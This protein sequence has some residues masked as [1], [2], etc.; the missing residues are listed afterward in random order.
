[1]N[2]F[3]QVPT[4]QTPCGPIFAHNRV[5]HF[6]GFYLS[7]NWRDATTAICGQ[8]FYL[9]LNGDHREGMASAANNGV[10]ALAK[11]FSDNIGQVSATSEHPWACGMTKTDPLKTRE[12]ALKVF[13]ADD[14]ELIRL[15][16]IRTVKG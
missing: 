9:V 7:H 12:Y 5:M 15:A 8:G 10:S 16:A 13:S 14:L 3:K 2:E 11:Y 6:E 4:I 1:M